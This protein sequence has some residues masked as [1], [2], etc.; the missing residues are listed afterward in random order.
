MLDSFAKI[1]GNKN[2]SSPVLKKVTAS[3]TVEMANTLLA[4]FF[5]PEIA[6]H[7]T[8]AYVKHGALYVACLSG[9]AAQEIKLRE[10]ELLKRLRECAPSS[11]LQKI[12][13]IL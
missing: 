2:F 13:Y 11:Q 6:G 10:A 8:A 5:G 9:A 1:I 4:E 12:H 3:L 7:A